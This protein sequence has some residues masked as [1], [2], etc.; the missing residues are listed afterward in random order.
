MSVNQINV[1]FKSSLQSGGEVKLTIKQKKFCVDGNDEK[2]EDYIWQIPVSVE[3][4]NWKKT[5]LITEKEQVI[6]L[7]G[8]PSGS[9]IKVNIK[10]L[11]PINYCR[12]HY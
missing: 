1:L 10:V 4:K 9:W 5:F 8:A 11:S 3:A 7:K 2:F 12:L 6:T